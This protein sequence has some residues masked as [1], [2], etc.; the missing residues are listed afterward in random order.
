MIPGAQLDEIGPAGDKI[1]GHIR[2]GAV[3]G[4]LI[5]V[6]SQLGPTIFIKKCNC[7]IQRGACD[8]GARRNAGL[9]GGSDELEEVYVPSG[10]HN[11]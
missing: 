8:L 2:I 10:A 4:D 3:I 5:I 6:G 9:A 1:H 7:S 11:S